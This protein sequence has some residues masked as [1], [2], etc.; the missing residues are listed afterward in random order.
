MAQGKE[1]R[2]VPVTEF[3]AEG[4]DGR[5][6]WARLLAFSVRDDYGTTF[7]PGLF[8]AQLRAG[9]WPPLLYGH[10]WMDLRAV[11]GQWMDR[12]WERPATLDL[13]A[14]FDDFEAVPYARQ[15][16]TQLR[17]GTLK[18]FSVGFT[19]LEDRKHPDMEN[20]VEITEAYLDEGSIVP[21]GAV[22]GTRLLQMRASGLLVPSELAAQ[23]ITQLGT[24]QIDLAVAL[25]TLKEASMEKPQDSNLE[26]NEPTED[27]PAGQPDIKEGQGT[28]IS[29]PVPGAEPKELDSEGQEILAELDEQLA[30]VGA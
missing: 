10:N 6:F 13:L 26:P 9:D 21:R 24:G 16:S 18:E 1:Y 3:R 2:R 29:E 27:N 17:S 11:L 12:D 23:V 8:D 14:G 30:G 25:T 15:A 28:P 5:R 4:D 20:T 22:P 7:R 19:R